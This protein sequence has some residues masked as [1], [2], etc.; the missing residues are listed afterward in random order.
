MGMK[1]NTETTTTVRQTD[2]FVGLYEVGDDCPMTLFAF[3]GD[4]LAHRGD[5][6]ETVA[7]LNHLRPLDAAE[8]TKACAD[9]LADYRAIA[10]ADHT[11]DAVE[12][13]LELNTP[14]A[15]G[16]G[17]RRLSI[18]EP[19]PASFT[20]ATDRAARV[21]GLDDDKLPMADVGETVALDYDGELSLA[22]VTAVTRLGVKLDLY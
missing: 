14:P 13:Y 18:I 1:T 19:A 7:M 5:V 16:G 8:F 11:A 4:D 17:L 10:A 22:T 9:T 3:E 2:T 6:A 15:R 12:H 20:I 21:W